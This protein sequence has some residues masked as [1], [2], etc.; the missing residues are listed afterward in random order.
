[1]DLMTE[2]E[3]EGLDWDLMYVGTCSQSFGFVAALKCF[4]LFISVI[5]VGRE[6][7]WSDQR[8]PFLTY[9]T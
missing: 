1:M 6:C 8:K 5:L 9:T 7:K 4:F 3:D 2:V